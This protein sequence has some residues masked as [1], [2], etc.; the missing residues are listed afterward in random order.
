M[1]GDKIGIGVVGA[2]AIYGW[3]MRA[4][5]PALAALS[6]FE[7]VAVCTAHKETAEESG[8]HYGA[9][10]AFHDYREMVTHPDVDLVTVSVRVPFHDEIVMAGLEAGKPVFCEWPLGANLAEAEKMANLAKSKG[11]KTMICLQARVDPVLL[12]LR[13]LV[14]EG[15]VGE[16]LSCNMTMFLG[17]LLQRGAG[18]AWTA[19]RNKGAT[20]LSIATGHAI[21]VVCLCVGEFREVSAQ[22]N[23]QVPAWDLADSGGT[24]NVTAPDNV[25]VSGT[26]ENGAAASTHVATVPWNGTGWRMEVYGRGGTLVASSSQMVQFAEIHL[27]GAQGDGDME[28]IS[29]PDRLSWVPGE[30]PKGAPFNVGQL[31]R[32]LSEAM[33]QDKAADPDFDLAVKR[34]RLLEA[35]QRSSDQGAR[36]SVQ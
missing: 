10:H 28:H 3:A 8:R 6:E 16:V 22:V 30:M 20:T 12:R 9:R 27:H 33:G 36:V 15:Y 18:S 14:Q 31:Y 34:H 2:N 19:D 17:G 29:I 7:L 13:E 21:D 32:R 5:M 23:T 35:I 26:L 11:L 1:P 4:H 25:L 24:V